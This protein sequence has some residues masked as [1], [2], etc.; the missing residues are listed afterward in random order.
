MHNCV[1]CDHGRL[2]NCKKKILCKETNG[3]S[4]LQL[5]SMYIEVLC[6]PSGEMSV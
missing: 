4:Q 3:I 5:G 1:P 2:E 6:I